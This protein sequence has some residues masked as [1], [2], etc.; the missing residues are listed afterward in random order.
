M[1]IK[2]K[3]VNRIAI[4]SDPAM[5]MSSLIISSILTDIAEAYPNAGVD[6]V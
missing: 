2:E 4:V 1:D 5:L 6:S 3:R